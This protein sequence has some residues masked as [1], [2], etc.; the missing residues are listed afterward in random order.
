MNQPP[1]VQFCGT[2]SSVQRWRLSPNG[3]WTGPAVSD[4]RTGK[5]NKPRYGR[6]P[7]PEYPL[8]SSEVHLGGRLLPERSVRSCGV[9]EA[10]IAGQ[11][12]AQLR[13]VGVVSQINVFVLHRAPQ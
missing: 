6:D 10:K 2:H 3:S 8:F 12:G 5:P 7:Y 11:S 1:D 9:V 13:T 4:R